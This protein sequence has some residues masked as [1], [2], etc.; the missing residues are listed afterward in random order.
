MTR[1]VQRHRWQDQDNEA[2]SNA[3]ELAMSDQC[4]TVMRAFLAF[5]QLTRCRSMG[6]DGGTRNRAGARSARVTRS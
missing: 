4:A 5:R 2:D 1:M 3:V 6:A